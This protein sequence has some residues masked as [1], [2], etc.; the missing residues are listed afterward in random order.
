MRRST[1]QRGASLARSTDSAG[2]VLNP[3]PSSTLYPRD[4]H[5]ALICGQTGCGKTE[6]MLDLLEGPYRGVFRYI[7]ILCPSIRF[8]KAYRARGWVWNDPRIFIV[9]PGEHLHEWLMWIYDTFKGRPTLY[10]IDDMAGSKALSKKKTKLS[11]LAFSGRHALQSV[12]IL[13]QKYNSV[14]TDFREQTR[15]VAL[16]HCKDRDS[17]AE[18][19]HENDVIP[20]KEERELVRSLLAAARHSKVILHT[21]QPT[22]YKVLKAGEC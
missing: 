2:A 7:V 8:N 1:S 14:V 15:W 12:W 9:N 11:D 4:A 17:F 16:F 20:S 21:D 6:Y 3:A 10:I 19:L 13:T 18:C 5:V 22:D